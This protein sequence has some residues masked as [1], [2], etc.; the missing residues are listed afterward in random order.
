VSGSAPG[1]GASAGGAGATFAQPTSA[2]KGL[3]NYNLDRRIKRLYVGAGGFQRRRFRRGDQAKRRFAS[4]LAKGASM[5]LDVLTDALQA[6]VADILAKGGADTES[7]LQKS[8]G[9]YREAL[10]EYVNGAFEELQKLGPDGGEEPLFKGLGT[11]GRAA[12]LLKHL[13]EKIDCMKSGHDWPGSNDEPHDPAPEEMHPM[14][15]GL[16]RMAELLLHQ[17]VNDHVEPATDDE[18]EGGA[19]GM[20]LISV[21][22]GSDDPDND[23]IVKTALPEGLAKFAM[24]PDILAGEAFSLGYGLLSL[25]GVPEQAL[26]KAFDGM[27]PGMDPN[28]GDPASMQDDGSLDDVGDPFDV[29][30]KLCAALMIQIDHCRAIAY[31]EMDPAGDPTGDQSGMASQDGT[32]SPDPQ[33]PNADPTGGMEQDPHADPTGPVA[34]GPGKSPMGSGNEDHKKKPPMRKSAD[35]PRVA[36]LEAKLEKF[37]GLGD[38]LGKLT[39]VVAS[40][41]SNT[42]QPPRGPLTQIAPPLGKQHDNVSAEER[43]LMAQSQEQ[44][45][46]AM[47][48]AQRAEELMKMIWRNGPQEPTG[49]AHG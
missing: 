21:P 31:G 39:D 6:S 13:A 11:V 34:D 12:G 38:A 35:D 33:D 24:H 18:I 5:D 23:V 41:Q 3:Q 30:G 19:P 37:A 7:L 28:N 27:D 43:E 40:M 17:A 44:Q 16:V 15:D 46:L 10:G 49:M 45:L 36:E 42:M 29:A 2:T 26:E 47:Q 22:D 4:T 1:G 9:E 20:M 8:F 14:M 48:P 32:V 25:A